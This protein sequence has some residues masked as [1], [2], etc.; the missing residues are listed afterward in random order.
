MAEGFVMGG[1]ALSQEE[2]SDMGL[3]SR[4]ANRLSERL[5]GL[6]FKGK[7]AKTLVRKKPA[8]G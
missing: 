7:T 5:E 6:I 1:P 4:S 2:M 8:V 3:C